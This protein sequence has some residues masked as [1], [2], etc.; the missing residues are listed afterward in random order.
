MSNE[1]EA[2]A[3]EAVRCLSCGASYA[4]PANGGTVPANPGCPVCGY[5]GWV[6]AGEVREPERHRFAEDPPQGRHA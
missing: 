2:S 5:V 3:I 6:P 1:P 4:K